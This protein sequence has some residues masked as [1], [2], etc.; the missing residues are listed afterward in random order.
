ML[1]ACLRFTPSL[2]LLTSWSA[3]PELLNSRG[4]G[5]R[6]LYKHMNIHVIAGCPSFILFNL[7]LEVDVLLLKDWS[8]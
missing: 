7:F 1:Y 6:R 4:R 2:I 3:T 8:R 5:V